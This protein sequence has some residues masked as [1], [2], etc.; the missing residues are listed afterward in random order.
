MSVRDL[1]CAQQTTT[2]ESSF[3]IRLRYILWNLQKEHE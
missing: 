3:Q 1:V 2:A